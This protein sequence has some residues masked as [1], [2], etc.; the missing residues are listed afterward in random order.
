MV[1]SDINNC[2]EAIERQLGWG[3]SAKW[4]NHDF[5]L[6]AEDIS[7]KTGVK[8][9][10]TT[11]RRIW[12]KVAYDNQPT[13][14]TLN[15]L[16]KYLGY[17]HWRDFQN[18]EQPKPEAIPPENVVERK[19]HKTKPKW[20]KQKVIVAIVIVLAMFS[21]YFLIDRRQVFFKEEEVTFKSRKVSIGLPN[22]VI[23]DYDVSKV[24]ADSFH[25]QQSWDRRR[26]VRVSPEDRQHTSFY[27][28]PGYFHAKL[29]A[30]DQVIKEH[31]V[32]VE[33][34]GWIGMIERFPEPI[35][36]K[37]MFTKS[38]GVLTTDLSSLL[39]EER[40]YRDNRFWVDYYY[41]QDLGAND[42][43]NFE[44]QCRIKNETDL[45]SICRESRIS[46]ICSAGRFNVPLCET[47]CVSNINVTLGDHYL[48]GKRV[49]L[50]ALGCNLSEWVD[51]KLKVENKNCEIFINNDLKLT[52]SYS[53]DLGKI[54]GFKFKFNGIGKIDHL[55][56]QD[57]N[58]QVLFEE[59]FDELL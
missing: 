34:N 41:V 53:S 44:Y 50:S 10:I 46:I 7:D 23:F 45:G 15:V 36:T 56:L 27:Y 19:P 54:Y 39:K 2:L 48:Q 38:D 3:S 37:D 30:N 29:I 47:G 6:L 18:Q 4:T 16:A 22:T 32:L 14:T 31:E 49:D 55:R 51:F 35:Y 9:S 26:R 33:S 28:Y 20:N 8:L 52:K 11:L 1:Q 5:E 17:E 58:D 40:P 59:H 57:L 42:A 24:V 12:G 13:S 43:N 21:A 25:I